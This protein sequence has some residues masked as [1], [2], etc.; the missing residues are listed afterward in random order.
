M[1]ASANFA[2]NSPFFIAKNITFKNKAP[3]PVSGELA[4]R[5]VGLHIS[6]D[7]AAFVGCHCVGSQDT[8]YDLVGRHYFMDCYIEF[9]FRNDLSFYKGCHLRSTS[10]S[11]R[12]VAM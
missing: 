8:L 10:R 5:A 7:A 6:M 1:F 2:V 11:Y 12:V 3:L 4:K 9:V